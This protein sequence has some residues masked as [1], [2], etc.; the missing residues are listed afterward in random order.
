MNKVRLKRLFESVSGGSWGVEPENGEVA[1]PCV[2]GTDF[3]YRAL[4]SNIQ[5]APV[6]GFSVHE[7]KT[8]AARK[9]DL[10]IEKS[11]GG[12][13]QPVG[14]A[15]LH[16]SDDVV[17]PTNFAARLS[18]SVDNDS[19]FVS[20]LLSSLYESGTTRASIKQTTGIQNLDLHSFLDTMISRP[21]LGKQR[22]IADFL[23]AETARIDALIAKKRE[24][25]RLLRVRYKEEQR[26][27][28][29][30]GLDP[31]TGNGLDVPGWRVAQLGVLVGLQ[32]GHDLPIDRRSNGTVPV[33]SSGGQSGW[34]EEAVVAG[35]G[36]VT[37]RYGTVGEVFYV[38]GPYWPLNTTLYVADFRG[39]HPRW[40]YH[41]LSVLPLDS[42]SAKSAVTGINRNVIGVLRVPVPPIPEQRR[43]A[44]ELDSEARRLESL[45]QRLDRQIKLLTEH[46]QA[47]ITAAVT[48]QMEVPGAMAR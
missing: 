1:L 33:I 32:R 3:D 47:L 19:R 18:P 15:V 27:R 44:D 11:G 26:A 4:R 5:R 13:Q 2:R 21:S 10:L 35:P 31:T 48:G 38:E 20:Y 29:L 7:V 14:R 28:M 17:M 16:D 9:G 36:V 37:G 23:D 43:L 22:A 46:R 12:E 34:H 40:V 45:T 41:L 39:R 8:R 25:S 24:L 30:R 42:D 6:R